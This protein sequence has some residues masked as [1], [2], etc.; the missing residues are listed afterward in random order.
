VS[1]HGNTTRSSSDWGKLVG[2]AGF[3]R[4]APDE[5]IIVELTMPTAQQVAQT[6]GFVAFS[7]TVVSAAAELA[8]GVERAMLGTGNVRTAQ[9]NAWDAICADRARAQARADMD[10]TVAALVKN[11]PRVRSGRVA[12]A[13]AALASTGAPSAR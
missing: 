7:L 9:G 11:G 3:R 2:V 13:G 8:A 6:G 12:G 4:P 10:R 5:K 1:L